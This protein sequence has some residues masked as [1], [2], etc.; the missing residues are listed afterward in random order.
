MKRTNIRHD[1]KHKKALNKRKKI[2][3]GLHQEGPSSESK[4]ALKSESPN[5]EVKS[6]LSSDEKDPISNNSRSEEASPGPKYKTQALL[7]PLYLV[8]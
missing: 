5:S 8:I 6:N 2:S 7:N 3:N 1:G 4:E